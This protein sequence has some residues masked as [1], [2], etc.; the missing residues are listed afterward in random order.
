MRCGAP[1][2]NARSAARKEFGRS[3]ASSNR[4]ARNAATSDEAPR[5]GITSTAVERPEDR[6][7]AAGGQGTRSARGGPQ[8][9]RK[10]GI[11]ITASPSQLGATTMMFQFRFRVLKFWSL[12]SCIAGSSELTISAPSGLV[13]H[14]LCIHSHAAG[15]RRMAASVTAM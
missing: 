10:K 11:A 9:A 4:R 12:L 7:R 2:R 14:R 13:R 5:R 8:K 3:H 6:C 15:S 1:D